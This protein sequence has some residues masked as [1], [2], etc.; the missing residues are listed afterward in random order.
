MCC[1][2]TKDATDLSVNI[3]D[4]GKVHLSSLVFWSYPFLISFTIES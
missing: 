1:K 3:K 4:A 2:H